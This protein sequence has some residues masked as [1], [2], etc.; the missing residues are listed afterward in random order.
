MQKLRG[1]PAPHPP[2]LPVRTLSSMRVCLVSREFV[3]FWGAGIGTY[4]SQMAAAWRAGGAGGGAWGG[5]GGGAGGG[6]G[7]QGGAAGR[8]EVHVVCPAYKDLASRGPRLY[9]GVHF[10]GVNLREGMAGWDAYRFDFMRRAMGVYHRLLELHARRPFDYIEFPEYW[11]EGYFALRGR[12]TLEQFEGAVLGVR[13]H[14]PTWECRELNRDAWL[15]DEIA[16]LEHIEDETMRLADVLVS[17]TRSLLENVTARLGLGHKLAAVVPYPF[18]VDAAVRELGAAGAMADAGAPAAD[19]EREVLYFGRIEHRK[20]VHVLIEAAQQ[21]LEAGEGAFAGGRVRFR[22]VGGDTPSGPSGRPM[23]PHVKKMV[24]ERWREHI[25]FE[26]ARPREEL[27]ALIRSADVCCFPSLWENFPNA[28]LEAMSLGAVVVGSDAGGMAEIIEDGTSGVLFRAAEAGDLARALRRGLEDAPLRERAQREAPARIRTLC[29]PAGIVRQME[30]VIRETGEARAQVGGAA[31]RPT[32]EQTEHAAL[33][34]PPLV[35]IIIPHYNLGAYLPETIASARAQ[36]F[37][38]CEIIVVDDGSTDEA[39]LKVVAEVEAGK[40]GP[41]RVVRKRNGGLSSARNAGTGAA[42][43]R[44]VVPLDADDVL[45]PMFVEKMLT[46]ARLNPGI[47]YATSLVSFFTEEQ[48]D[49]QSGWVPLGID[50]DILAYWN[51]AGSCTALIERAAILEIG[52]YDEWLTSFEDWDL[53]CRLAARGQR[54]AIVPEFLIGYRIRT[55]SMLRT[56]GTTNRARIRA[57]LYGKNAGLSENPDRTQRLQLAGNT[58]DAEARAR[59]LIQENIRYRVADRL[60]DALKR[61]RLQG[62]IKDFTL[63]VTKRDGN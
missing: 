56:E 27:G 16:W 23:L 37:T 31:T 59:Q 8:H 53:Y 13:L 21:L 22:L 48:R 25:V 39:S 30:A 49:L 54:G 4:A 44:W 6:G 62:R 15:N 20:G 58:D 12:R 50:R 26:K 38:D 5:A 11:G 35:S 3:P 52:G 60:N 57:Y 32:S 63:K 1:K 17:P 34:G 43:G 40:H 2:D 42:R 46:A 19:R 9:P 33:E 36:T 41:V 47:A 10:H 55:A 28:C 61:A 45:D 7:G 18:D 51:C 29:E 14:T 24:R